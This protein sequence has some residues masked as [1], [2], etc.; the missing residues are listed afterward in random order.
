MSTIRILGIDPSLTHTGYC[1]VDVDHASRSIVQVIEKGTVVTAK[2]K[3]KTV[4]RSSDD[5]ARAHAIATTLQDV[6]DRNRI[7]IACAE[8]PSGG[9]S[10]SAAK[11]FGISIGI[12]ASLRIPLIEVS[13][14][15]VKMASAGSRVADKEDIVRWA[16]NLTR[17][18]P[19]EWNTTPKANDW[20]I[21]WKGG[22]VTKTVEHEADSIAG[23]AAAIAS[24]EFRQLSGML[25]AI[26]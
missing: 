9:Q 3:S 4:R 14:M 23:V 19:I 8:I 2:S 21:E 15:E 24:N 12:L 16:V 20:A 10:A 18:D 13:P 7:K 6:I 17:E 22:F 25:S 26:I 1:V 5:V 11:A